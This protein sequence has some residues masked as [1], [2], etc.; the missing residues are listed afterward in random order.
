MLLISFSVCLPVFLSVCLSV[1]VSPMPA[2]VLHIL[3]STAPKS[4]FSS[5]PSSWDFIAIALVYGRRVSVSG[6]IFYRRAI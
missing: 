5:F 4:G 2:V 6:P 3:L 1:L